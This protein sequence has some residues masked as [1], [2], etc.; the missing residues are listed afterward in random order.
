MLKSM[1][2]SVSY[3]VSKRIWTILLKSKVFERQKRA[4][5]LRVI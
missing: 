5:W 1:L 2:E 3:R 4:V